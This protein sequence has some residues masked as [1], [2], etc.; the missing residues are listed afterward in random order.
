MNSVT[1]TALHFQREIVASDLACHDVGAESWLPPA[2]RVKGCAA[3]LV[4]AA[5]RPAR[6]DG[7][8]LWTRLCVGAASCPPGMHPSIVGAPNLPWPGCLRNG[9]LAVTTLLLFG[10]GTVPLAWAGADA[11]PPS[12]RGAASS[13][14]LASALVLWAGPLPS[15]FTHRALQAT[16]AS[17]T[18]TWGRI[19]LKMDP[20]SSVMV[21]SCWELRARWWTD[22]PAPDL[23][24]PQKGATLN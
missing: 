20:S 23:M 2:A 13:L 5:L 8:L 11:I 17:P 3:F 18:M 6:A 12:L 7:L 19:T 10:T 1:Q 21:G 4:G 22:N 15:D 9:S 24:G 14:D 16:L